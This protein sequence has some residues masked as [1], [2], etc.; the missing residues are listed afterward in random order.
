MKIVTSVTL[1]LKTKEVQAK[2]NGA[3]R[4]GLRNTIVLIA[5]YAVKNSPWRYGNNRRSLHY[6]VSGMGHNQASI[7][8][9]QPQDTWTGP[10]TS[11]LDESK[12]ESVVYSTSGYGGYLETGTS[13]MPARPYIEPG[14]ELNKDKLV[15]FIKEALNE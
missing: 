12:L 15:P 4:T 9:R 11:I 10:D 3:C 14:Y 13:K 8:G 7:E 2:V 6:A 5:N 1:N